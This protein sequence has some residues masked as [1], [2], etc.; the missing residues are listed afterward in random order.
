MRIYGV[1]FD[2]VAPL[3]FK[4]RLQALY[5]NG[6]FAVKPDYGPGRV[7]ID[8][9]G[10]DPRG[11]FW[12]DIEKGD[13]TP[14]GVPGW[15]D[16]RRAAGLGA[17]GIY[18]DRDNLPAVEAAAGARPHLLWVATLD[19]TMNIGPVPGA[20]VLAAVQVFPAVMLGFNAD[21]S[22]VVDPGYWERAL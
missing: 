12:R 11:A 18:C 10:T 1:Q 6:R 13:G 5:I 20:G 16:E 4:A 2:S 3:P 19:G 14:A 8:V 22:V 7:Y 17:G 9:N 21:L 15:L